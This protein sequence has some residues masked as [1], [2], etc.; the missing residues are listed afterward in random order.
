[1]A[2]WFNDS[3]VLKYLLQR[4]LFVLEADVSSWRLREI[5]EG[6]RSSMLLGGERPEA[7]ME[8]GL[9]NYED[10]ELH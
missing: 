3:Y 4:Q 10:S 6:G 2:H 8:Q 5:T 7:R 1:M 9:A